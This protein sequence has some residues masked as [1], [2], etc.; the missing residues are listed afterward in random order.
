MAGCSNVATDSFCDVHIFEIAS[1]ACLVHRKLL[2]LNCIASHAKTAE[3]PEECIIEAISALSEEKSDYLC[4]IIE[5]ELKRRE[6]ILDENEQETKQKQNDM[7]KE[8]NA[9]AEKLSLNV[10]KMKDD[11]LQLLSDKA[12]S[13]LSKYETQRLELRKFR[14]GMTNIL[15]NLPIQ[16]EA[17]EDELLQS[18]R[19]LATEV[20]KTSI[21][22]DTIDAAF[23]PNKRLKKLLRTSGCELGVVALYI[24]NHYDLVLN[25]KVSELHDSAQL[26]HETGK[27]VDNKNS[28]IPHQDHQY[29]PCRIPPQISCPSKD[30]AFA[31]TAVKQSEHRKGDVQKS[32]KDEN[33]IPNQRSFFIYDRPLAEA[34]V[35]HRK[36]EI[37]TDTYNVIA[38]EYEQIPG[39]FRSFS[40]HAYSVSAEEEKKDGEIPDVS[41]HKF[42]KR[43]TKSN[44]DNTEPKSVNYVDVEYPTRTSIQVPTPKMLINKTLCIRATSQM[45]SAWKFEQIFEF[46]NSTF[47]LF[48]P[49]NDA[50]VLA[51]LDGSV[52]CAKVHSHKISKMVK[53][54]PN[55]FGVLRETG[56]SI[57]FYKIVD[58]EIIQ[59]NKVNLKENLSFATGF[60]FDEQGRYAVSSPWN[61]LVAN[62][63]G[64]T[65]KYKLY[66]TAECKDLSKIRTIFDFKKDAIYILNN[67][68]ATLKR[69]N[70]E[71]RTEAWKIK[72]DQQ[73]STRSMCLH[74]NQLF[75]S[76]KHRILQFSTE[77]NGEIVQQD[78]SDLIDD[79]LGIYVTDDVIIVTSN[80][81]DI[82]QSSKLAFKSCDVGFGLKAS[83][84]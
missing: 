75:V 72:L 28:N 20:R 83:I 78:T 64:Q 11:A 65:V 60:D 19:Q 47:C 41:R 61:I 36:K 53:T 30:S 70:V 3:K 54:G 12:D 76:S 18:L 23:V 62:A 63:K 43:R 81:D 55:T 59:D 82:A 13:I 21:E 31:V 49:Q 29:T 26:E 2:C 79:C 58:N 84:V 39:L 44:S 57:E 67:T 32:S 37:K 17:S 50:L 45:I 74:K 77:E 22:K 68:R 25:Y 80:S 34:N 6:K 71:T 8:I 38:Q 73:F 9:T 10:K 52:T 24:E 16:N 42:E 7:E 48:S 14:R 35:C 4:M 40:E 33:E 27:N 46:E 69:I 5:N 66:C 51:K 56:K 15:N 1:A